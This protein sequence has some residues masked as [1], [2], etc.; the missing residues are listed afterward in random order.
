MRPARVPL[1]PRR[2]DIVA[3]ADRPTDPRTTFESHTTVAAHIRDVRGLPRGVYEVLDLQGEAFLVTRD[4]ARDAT[5]RVAV[6]DDGQRRAW[7]QV[8]PAT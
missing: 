1:A 6:H 2:G 8:L 7:R 4:A 5:L 3:L